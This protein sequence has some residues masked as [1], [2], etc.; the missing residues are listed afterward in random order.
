MDPAHW[1]TKRA[2]C[3]GGSG[4]AGQTFTYE[5][6]EPNESTRGIAV[7]V[8]TLEANGGAIRS[9][10]TDADAHLSYTGLGRDPD[11]KVDWRLTPAPSGT[12]LVTGVAVVSDTGEDDT[13]D[14]WGRDDATDAAAEAFRILA[15][16]VGSDG[17]QFADE[18]E[19]LLRGFVDMLDAQVRRLD[20]SVDRLSPELR[21]LQREQ[22]GSE[23]ESRELEL[24]T[25]QAQNLGDRRAAFE[26]MRDL[27]ADAYRAE[28]G[29]VWRPRHGSN[30]SQTGKL[31]SAAIDARDFMRARKNRKTR[32]HLPESM[33]VA[34]T[35]GKE[36]RIQAR[37]ATVGLDEC[38][39]R[40]RQPGHPRC[41]LGVADLQAVAI[42]ERQKINNTYLI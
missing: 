33:L 14:I 35:G 36:A 4:T 28:T 37:A 40:S 30:V 10:V 16:G 19:S 32:A 24:V 39:Q 15:E 7:P 31:T 41:P 29:D 26:Q 42:F 25:D 12:V 20:R 18:R 5:V 21:D 8:D 38:P 27:A 34:I 17:T 6:V 13:R 2:A 1:A 11:H 9:A 3:E 22:D 23:I